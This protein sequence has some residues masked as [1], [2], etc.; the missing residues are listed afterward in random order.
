MDEADQRLKN[1]VNLILKT[2]YQLD[3][4]ALAFLKKAAQK[5]ETE[6]AVFQTLKMLAEAPENP[7]FVS[8]DHLEMNVT[9]LIEGSQK[10]SQTRSKGVHQT[11][12][13]YAKEVNGDVKVIDDLTE[14]ALFN[15]KT[16]GYL[17]YFRD[18]FQKIERIL[19][20]RVDLKQAISINAAHKMPLKTKFKII[21]II[22]EKKERKNSIVFQIEDS[23]QNI[24]IIVSSRSDKLVFEKARR[25]FIDQI[26]CI[27]LVKLQD[28]F[29]LVKE[30][31]NPDI[32]ERKPTPAKDSVYAAL[33]SDLHIGSKKFLN[34]DFER[35]I[36]WLHGEE[37][38]SRQ[39]NIAGKIKYIVIAGDLVDGIGVYPNHHKEL[40]VSDIYDQYSLAS[41]L[42]EK[43][44]EYIEIVIIPGN[45]DAT[46][47]ALPQPAIFKKYSKAIYNLTNVTMLGDPAKICLHGVNLLVHHG[48]GLDDVISRVP[49][50]SYKTLEEDIP[51]AMEYL[52][53]T[54]HLA[55]IYGSKTPI[56]PALTDELVITSPPDIFHTGHVH[57]MN[58]KNYRGTLMV[59]SGTWQAQ[60]D[61]QE[62]M[63]LMPTPGVIPIVNLQTFKVT[64]LKF[65]T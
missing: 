16:D 52:L 7:L 43:I 12:T 14:T 44:P 48:R 4:D 13:P 17:K 55:P 10:R 8:K 46:R 53:K 58:C 32:P 37:G 26:V 62:R 1:L 49:D 15:Q 23:E 18:R 22:T 28:D 36:R 27:E 35:F 25:L 5:E 19:R 56:A 51:L 31:V 38:N 3:A 60:T 30:I 2:G 40:L 6:E 29:F 63:G 61:F 50:V 45:H 9:K 54:R 21:G 64:P 47:Q 24:S 20:E 65:I 39:K 59:N 11:Y 57:V 34:E 33:T 42:I 41:K